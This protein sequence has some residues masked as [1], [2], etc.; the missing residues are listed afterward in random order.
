MATKP[1]TE[2]SG[3]STG[4]ILLVEEYSALQV[5]ITSA[6]S[7]FAPLHKVRIAHGFA[8]AEAAAERMRPDLFLLDLD[9]PPSGEITIFQ[10]LKARHPEARMLV[11][12]PG[13]SRELRA[14]RGTA[15]AIQFIE[16]PFDL[17]EFG[18][19]V[20]ALLGPWTLPHSLHPRGTLLDL[21]L[22]DLVQLKCLALSNGVLRLETDDGRSGAIYFRRG[23]ICHAVTGA[24][25]RRGGLRGNGPLGGLAF[26]RN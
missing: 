11:L 25:D 10:R 16:K 18:A 1:P 19:A 4:G 2:S 24:T 14:E 22:I 9:P 7:K 26:E 6:L 12:A 5:A 20:Q 21:H 17:D 15:G 8:E 13:T 3:R 23:Q